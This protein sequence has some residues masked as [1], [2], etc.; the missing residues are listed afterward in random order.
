MDLLAHLSPC[1]KN[2]IKKGPNAAAAPFLGC[3]WWAG[4]EPGQG[5]L[6]ISVPGGRG[7]GLVRVGCPVRFLGTL[8]PG[9]ALAESPDL[10]LAVP[11]VLPRCH[12]L[13]QLPVLCHAA[14][15]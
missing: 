11:P 4:R 15:P 12:A 3:R 10:G 5:G 9:H 2:N 14:R 6:V 13:L 8:P 7:V 1:M